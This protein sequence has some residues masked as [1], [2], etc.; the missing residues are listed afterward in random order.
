MADIQSHRGPDGEG[1]VFFFGNGDWRSSQCLGDRELLQGEQGLMGGLVHRRLAIIDL[2]KEASQPMSDESNDCWIT[3]NGEIYNYVELRAELQ[4]KG[5]IFRSQSDTE[6]ILHAYLEWGLNCLQRFNGMFSFAIWDSRR[7]RLFCA[8]DRLGIKPFVYFYKNQ[9]FLFASEP[10]AIL[11]ALKHKCSPNVAAMADYLS[12]SFVTTTETMFEGIHRLT[13]GSWLIADVSGIKQQAY[14]NPVFRYDSSYREENCAEEL[15]DLLNDSI[16]LQI[17]SDVPVGAHLSGGIDSSTVCCLAAR[18]I[19]HLLTFTARFPEGGFFDEAPFARLV[20]EEISADYREIVPCAEQLTH[21]LPRIL[22]HLDE[23]VEGAAIVGKYHIAKL[24]S[25]SVK[26]VLTGHGVD[27]LF[28]GYDWYIKNLFTAGCFGATLGNR[29]SLK[30]LFDT[31]R[32]ENLGRLAKSL[33]SNVGERSLG[34]IFYRNWDRLAKSQLKSIF[35]KEVLD[36][37]PKPKQRFLD[38]YGLLDEKRDGDKMFKFDLRH[39]LEALLTS[40]DRL[41]MAFS[42]ESRVP[43]LDHRIVELAGRVGY[44][45]KTEPGRSKRLLRL[46]VEGIVPEPILARRDKMGFPTPV[47]AWLR[48]PNLGLYDSLVFN[49]NSFAR[50]YFDLEYVQRLLKSRLHVGS[51]S[52]ETL[53]RILNLSVWGQVFGLD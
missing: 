29:S 9:S 33:Y 14:W 37:Q 25:Q 8:R 44:E 22:H 2:S 24:V 31:V 41:S 45:R 21:T 1:A 10:K 32:R 4:D 49:D 46:A 23:P 40:E 18:H 39:Y 5:H 26:V 28:G 3:Y 16:R 15:L 17:R 30:F 52:S 20:A 34:T 53:W 47:Q 35:R 6:V 11:A 27:E 42:V 13:P 36:G 51:S 19:P 38:A 12:F 48:D 43:L 50:R 7:R